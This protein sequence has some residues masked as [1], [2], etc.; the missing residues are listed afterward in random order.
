MT[1]ILTPEEIERM[2]NDAEKFAE[3]DKKLKEAHWHKK[4]IEAVLLS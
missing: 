3:E 4:W 1:K 2:V